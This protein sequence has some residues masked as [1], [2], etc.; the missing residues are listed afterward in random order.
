MC[1]QV[2]YTCGIVKSEHE[3]MDSTGFDLFSG[4]VWLCYECSKSHNPVKPRKSK[5]RHNSTTKHDPT[6]QGEISSLAN[7][8]FNT[9]NCK[10]VSNTIDTHMS[11]P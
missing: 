9:P 8:F 6:L 10:S 7:Q 4:H 3:L 5:I 2:S 1:Y 11:Q